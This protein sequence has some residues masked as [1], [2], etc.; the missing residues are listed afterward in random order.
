MSKESED[1]DYAKAESS[2]ALYRSVVAD[3][4]DDDPR[5]NKSSDDSDE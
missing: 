2:D 5:E 3:T 4:P 1:S